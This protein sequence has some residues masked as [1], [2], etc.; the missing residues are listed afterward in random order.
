MSMYSVAMY[1]VSIKFNL[2]CRTQDF[3]IAHLDGFGQAVTKCVGWYR[4]CM[5]FLNSVLLWEAKFLLDQHLEAFSIT[6][7]NGDQIVLRVFMFGKSKK[8]AN[9]K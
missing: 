4:H 5:L 7:E 6:F 8:E 3:T 2:T 9:R 1:S